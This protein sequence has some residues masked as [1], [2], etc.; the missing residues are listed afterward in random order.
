[1]TRPKLLFLCQTLPYPPDGGV[2]IRSYNILRLLAQTYDIHA[3][4]FYRRASQRDIAASVT[5]LH[6]L[7][8]STV[9]P[10]DS[11]SSRPRL[12]W[13]HLRS[14]A[15]GRVYTYF[16]YES[17]AYASALRQLLATQRFDLVHVDSLDLS[18]YLDELGDLP[19][20][21][22]HHNVESELLRRRARLEGRTPF[23]AY[24]HLQGALMAREERRWCAKVDLNVTVS[25][26]DA[27]VLAAQ[28]PSAAVTVVPN[29]V[30][31]EAFVPA[32]VPQEGCV[33]VGG[34]TWFPNK[35]ALE[36][37]AAD[38]LPELRAIRGA[39]PTVTWVGRATADAQERYR[40]QGVS[41]T[42][43]VDDIRPYVQRAACY[44]VPIRVGGGTRLKILDAWALGKAVVSTS[45]GCEGLDARDGDNI[46]IRDDARSFAAAVQTVL[47]D[48]R[49]RE[50]LGRAGRA[51]AE[52]TYSWTSIGRRMTEEYERVRLGATRGASGR[53]AR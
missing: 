41:L 40:A 5:A 28:N 35:D 23:G 31:I 48:E 52:N 7:A 49:L 39:A 2:S 50:R 42:G 3:L 6:T 46:L 22:V 45:V 30:D 33:F 20:V 11:E 10:I 29:G 4:F 1:M 44:L 25:A 27:R 18:R 17:R 24:L 26:A 51:T 37:F 53:Q 13:D 8:K 34:M 32:D 12:V 21:C 36:W 9:T 15:T 19:V 43:Y 14:M 38:V 16:V 47:E